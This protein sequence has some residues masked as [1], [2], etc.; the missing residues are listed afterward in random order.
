MERNGTP[1]PR[2]SVIRLSLLDGTITFYKSISDATKE[3]YDRSTIL[4]C[5]DKRFKQHKNCKWYYKN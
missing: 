2:I 4:G 5:C 3:G 1:K